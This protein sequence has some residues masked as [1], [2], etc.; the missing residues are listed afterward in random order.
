[1]VQGH[2]GVAHM[3]PLNTAG[4][5]ARIG[6]RQPTQ[7][8]HVRLDDCLSEHRILV[9]QTEMNFEF[10]VIT[11]EKLRLRS[12]SAKYGPLITHAMPD[13]ADSK[14]RTLDNRGICRQFK[15]QT[16]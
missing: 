9:Q 11:T 7:V 5:S 3:A 16:W 4:L 14:R 15:A 1:M 6:S 12:P 13:S 8:H 2:A 10:L